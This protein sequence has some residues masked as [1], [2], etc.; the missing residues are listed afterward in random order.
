MR[1]FIWIFLN[2]LENNR[3]YR[4]NQ[5]WTFSI[6]HFSL[7]FRFFNVRANNWTKEEKIWHQNEKGQT[8][9]RITTHYASFFLSPLSQSSHKM[10][11]F[12]FFLLCSVFSLIYILWKNKRRCPSKFCVKI[13]KNAFSFYLNFLFMPS[14]SK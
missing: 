7:I 10:E 2:S 4:R 11:P 13:L 12:L 8:I 9:C 5:L 6:P 3:S 1:M 14:I